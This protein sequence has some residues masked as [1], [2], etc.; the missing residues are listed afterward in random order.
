MA[1]S[2]GDRLSECCE[3]TRVATVSASAMN[4]ITNVNNAISNT[5]S[6]FQTGF[7]PESGGGGSG[8]A[9]SKCSVGGMGSRRS[10]IDRCNL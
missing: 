10:K 1:R 4:P 2:A 5:S 9:F 8:G 7:S 3:E 6:R